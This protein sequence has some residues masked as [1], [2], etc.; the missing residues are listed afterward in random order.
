MQAKLTVGHANDPLEH[1]ADRVADAALG[2]LRGGGPAAE[3]DDLGGGPAPVR[4][5][6]PS[7][8]DPLGGLPVDGEVEAGI[9]SAR[10]GGR[11]VSR[12]VADAVGQASGADLSGV[13]VHTD[14]HA[15]GLS[16]S[17]Q[18]R[19]FTTGSDIFFQSGA[20]DPSSSSGRETLAHELAHVAQQGG[21]ARRRMVNRRLDP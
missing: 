16:R 1:E 17:L 4:R 21:G 6:G 20:Y 10:G 2:A 18:A 13:R 7:G 3:A 19:A 14:S 12:D 8:A 5:Q 11:P 9:Q 15:D